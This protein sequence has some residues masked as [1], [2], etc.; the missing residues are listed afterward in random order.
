M[1]NLVLTVAL[2][3]SCGGVE[4]TSKVD[5]IPEELTF[6]S[7][8]EEST[9]NLYLT[10]EDLPTCDESRKSHLA[11]VDDELKFYGCDGSNWNAL[12]VENSSEV[13][14]KEYIT[15]YFDHGSTDAIA[16]GFNYVYSR[17]SNGTV[18]VQLQAYLADLEQASSTLF[19][20]AGSIASQSGYV[21]IASGSSHLNELTMD[22]NH[23]VLNHKQTN[24]Y[25]GEEKNYSMP[26]SECIVPEL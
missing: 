1:K 10:R 16:Y 17:F 14:L 7:L 23:T 6:K 25:T 3:T 19:H 11:Y 15:C 22:E 8:Q 20:G 13:T 18:A 12:I 26:I 5:T 2:L 4:E 9:G 24:V 21:S